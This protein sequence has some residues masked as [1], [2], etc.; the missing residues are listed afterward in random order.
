MIS[1]KRL[2]ANR[3]NARKSR[4]PRTPEGKAAA[5]R[6]AL[7]HGITTITY[8]NPAF[9]GEIEE[10]ARALCE[11][12]TNPHL[13][14]HALIIAECDLVR[15][16]IRRESVAVVERCRDRNTIALA[17]G[18]NSLALAEARS[19]KTELAIAELKRMGVT[20]DAIP[21]H[22][23]E[24]LEED[25]ERRRYEPLEAPTQDR[26]EVEAFCEAI[27]DLKKL[28]RYE[29]R[30]WSRQKRAIRDFIGMKSWRTTHKRATID[31]QPNS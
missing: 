4:G 6:N 29:R 25:E 12:D 9:A 21:A 24:E 8:R 10:R 2:A 11:G 14:R 1:S 19:R 30:A 5:S 18:D 31:L 22:L 28:E 13:F 27:P 20:I 26:D 17:K 23:M 7:R 16:L 3:V 15:H